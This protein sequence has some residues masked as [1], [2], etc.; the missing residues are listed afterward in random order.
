MQSSTPQHNYLQTEALYYSDGS[1]G[2]I[3]IP[4]LNL[5]TKV[6][7]GE[8]VESMRKGVG[9]FEFTSTFDGN[10]GIAGHNRGSSAYLSGIWNLRNGDEIIYTT[11]YGQRI[12]EVY[13]KEKISDTDYSKLGWSS[14][15]IIT[16]ITCVENQST[17]R[18]C[19][20]AKE[21]K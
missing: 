13:S 2:T 19:I 7:E 8:T 14:D 18:W 17:L 9:H 5:T 6:F 15:N 21:T 11:K 4:R 3:R 10:V 12:Y 16:L 20:V 1:I